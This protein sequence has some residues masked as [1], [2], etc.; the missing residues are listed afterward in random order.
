MPKSEWLDWLRLRNFVAAV[1]A[2]A[3]RVVRPK[4]FHRLREMF[5]DVG[6]IE[7]DV[8]HYRP[9]VVA[10]ENDM[11]AFAGRTAALDHDAD[12]ARRTHRRVRNICRNKKRFPLA[13]EMIDNL[14]AF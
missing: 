12:G 11:L 10:V 3:P 4:I 8:L 9:A 2:R 14:V 1:F 7:V 13:H 6:A 5:D